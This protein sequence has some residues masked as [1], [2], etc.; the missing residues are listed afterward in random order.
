MPPWQ[1]LD[2]ALTNDG[3]ELTLSTLGP[4]FAMRVDGQELMNSDSHGS[5]ERL[6]VHGCAGLAGRA[7]VRVLIGG[8]GMGFIARAA[9]GVLGADAEVLIVESIAAVVR[10]NREILGHLAGAPLDDPR[11]SVL[12]GDVAETIDA[13][14]ERFDAILLDVDN[15]PMALTSYR[16]KRL[17]SAAGLGSAR[18]AL[19]P[20]GVLAVWSTF[21][22][23]RFTARLRETGFE[24]TA[25][26]VLAGDGT[27][28]R[29]V[30]WVA[31]KPPEAS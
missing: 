22:D 9:L 4:H 21:R 6:A 17:Y 12:E 3:G 26:R 25:K 7:G 20:S 27:P 10:W 14:R 30:V 24:V 18:A 28:R 8:L 2:R 23:A 5:E 15:G 16:N 31:R 29:H 19:R 1:L 11:V 13:A